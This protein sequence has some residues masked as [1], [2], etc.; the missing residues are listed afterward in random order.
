MRELIIAILLTLFL[1]GS[2]YLVA[3]IESIKC[4]SYDIGLYCDISLNKQP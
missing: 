2:A 1:I 3:H 4:E